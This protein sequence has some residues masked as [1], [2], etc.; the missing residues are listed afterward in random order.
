MG[1]FVIYKQL[2]PSSSED[3]GF[4]KRAQ[5]FALGGMSGM[6]A[7]VCIQP[8]DFV[9]TRMQLAG[10]MSATK[11][12]SPFR[13]C[14]G[15]LR[16]EGVRV[17][18]TGLSA[19]LLRQATYTTTRLGVYRELTRQLTEEGKPLPFAKKAL[20][21]LG[22]GAVGALVSTPTEVALIRMQADGNLPVEQR[23]NYRNVFDAFSRIFRSEGIAG[24]W[25]GLTP[26]VARAMAL[27]CGM[28]A[29]NDQAKEFLS[30]QLDSS[31]DRFPVRLG[32]SAMAG[33]MASVMTAP[34]DLIKSRIQKSSGADGQAL[35][36]NSLDCAFKIVRHEGPLALYKGFG[37]FVF[38]IAPH[39]MITLLVMDQLLSLARTASAFNIFIVREEKSSIED[40]L[41]ECH[42]RKDSLRREIRQQ[43]QDCRTRKERLRNEIADLESHNKKRKIAL[44]DE[45]YKVEADIDSLERSLRSAAA[46]ALAQQGNGE[47]AM[48]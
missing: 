30:Q 5:P 40:A 6:S 2:L 29:T 9:K 26:T 17:F 44:R 25:R 16:H 37:P 36:R 43:E 15:I 22:A 31:P 13:V 42:S 39:A 35:Y 8:I 32:A 46:T 33:F 10:E 23:H 48:A 11:Q 20:S 34:F 28:L 7:T 47:V 24:L 38:R 18:Y 14:G 27:N 45:L 21:G 4:M 41:R 12:P 3:V 19:A 1:T